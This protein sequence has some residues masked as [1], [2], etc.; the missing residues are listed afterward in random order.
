RRIV[1]VA[2][3]QR[4]ALDEDLAIRCELHVDARHGSANG[5]QAMVLPGRTRRRTALGRPVALHDDDAQV[6]PRLLQ[7]RRQERA[8]ADEQVETATEAAVNASEQDPT[9]AIGESTRDPSQ[10]VERRRPTGLLDLPLDRAPEQI[11]DLR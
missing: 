1:P 8:G 5:A 11:E 9:E 10:P 3:E 6:L 2:L 7:G 4:R